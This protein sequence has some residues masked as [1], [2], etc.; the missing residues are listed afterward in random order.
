MAR[1][2]AVFEGTFRQKRRAEPTTLSTFAPR[3][4]ETKR[5]LRTVAKY[6]QQ[7]AHHLIP[8]FGSKPIA[9]YDPSE[10]MLS[11]RKG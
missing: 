9:R 10:P 7:L 11:I 3:F 1:K 4:L 5:H 2:A 6:R 8:F